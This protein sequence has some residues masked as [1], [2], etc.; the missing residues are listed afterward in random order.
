M[1]DNLQTGALLG[2]LALGGVLAWLEYDKKQEAA[3]ANGAA[4]AQLPG[5]STQAPGGLLGGTLPPGMSAP[6]GGLAGQLD[7][8]RRQQEAAQR[9]GQIDTLRRD[10]ARIH[11]D[12]DVLVVQAQS[13]KAQT[14]DPALVQSVTDRVWDTCRNSGAWLTQ[15]ARCHNGNMQPAAQQAVATEWQQRIA[16]QLAPIQAQLSRLNAEQQQTVVNLGQLGY[17]VPLAQTKQVTV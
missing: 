9:Q 12:I 14:P 3:A 2:V 16:A 1:S 8:L 6:G 15:A 10:L 7:E 17:V 5:A 4:G 13:I 11:N